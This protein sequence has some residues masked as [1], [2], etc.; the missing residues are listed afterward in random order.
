MDTQHLSSIYPISRSCM[1]AKSNVSTVRN[2]E[3]VN[4]CRRRSDSCPSSPHLPGS[5]MFQPHPGPESASSG[6]SV[7]DTSIS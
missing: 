7:T 5:G 4:K 2:N 1:F 6:L 3:W